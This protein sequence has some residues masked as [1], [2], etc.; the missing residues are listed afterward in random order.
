ML[1]NVH[2]KIVSVIAWTL[3]IAGALTII[4][5]LFQNNSRCQK[6]KNNK[7]DLE[8]EPF[9]EE[10]QKTNV[11]RADIH[12]LEKIPYVSFDLAKNIVNYRDLKGPFVKKEDLLNVKGMG[13]KLLRLIEEYICLE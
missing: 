12:E 1:K 3:L 7:Q 2:K 5:K 9:F 8:K 10:N 11:N 4:K 6:E 13:P